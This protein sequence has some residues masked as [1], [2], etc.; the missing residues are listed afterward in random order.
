MVII[1]VDSYP[2]FHTIAFYAQ[3]AGERGERELTDTDA[4][5]F[6]PGRVRMPFGVRAGRGGQR[7]FRPRPDHAP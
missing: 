1:G 4:T 7:S 5:W 3:Q 2:N 6:N